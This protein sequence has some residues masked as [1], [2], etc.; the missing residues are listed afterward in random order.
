M[1]TS[2]TRKAIKEKLD[3]TERL[4]QD[5]KRRAGEYWREQ[6]FINL[7]LRSGIIFEVVVVFT[8]HIV[9]LNVDLKPKYLLD[10]I[11]KGDELKLLLIVFEFIIVVFLG[12]TTY[13]NFVSGYIRKA[14]IRDSISMQ[15]GLVA[16][17]LKALLHDIENLSDD[18]EVQRKLGELARRETAVTEWAEEATMWR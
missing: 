4:S 6:R 10:M 9:D 11:E 2:Q 16:A 15:Y 5:Y 7:I 12:F 13:W 3:E 18:D 14:E 8:A 1:M 17:E